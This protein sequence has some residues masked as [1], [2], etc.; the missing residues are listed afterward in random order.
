MN[1]AAMLADFVRHTDIDLL[2]LAGRYTLL[3]QDSLDD[4]L[5]LCVQRGVGI[6]AA[7]IFN[8]GLLARAASGDDAKYDYGDAPPELVARA[9]RDRRRSASATGRRCRRPRS[10]SRSRIRRSSA[11]A[12]ARV[13]REQIERNAALYRDADPGGS[14]ERAQADGLL[15]EDAPVLLFRR[16]SVRMTSWP[17]QPIITLRGSRARCPGRRS[18]ARPGRPRPR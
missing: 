7:G 8:S 15:R 4:L 13:R 3:E 6:V 10:P 18:A 12:S 11:S 9:R 2:M 17:L 1:Q 5:P 16:L 14:V